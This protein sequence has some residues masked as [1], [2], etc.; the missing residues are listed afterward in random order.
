VV[1]ECWQA[2]EFPHALR[3]AFRG[4]DLLDRWYQDVA[5]RRGGAPL[6]QHGEGAGGPPSATFL[7]VHGGLCMD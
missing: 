3:D 7:G 4:M 5:G 1:N 2:E 6:Y